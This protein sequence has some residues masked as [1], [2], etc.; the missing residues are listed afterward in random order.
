MFWIGLALGV[1]GLLFAE[2]VAVVVIG[3]SQYLKG[4]KKTKGG[5]DDG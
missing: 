5:L 2:L 3:V 1:F 4:Q